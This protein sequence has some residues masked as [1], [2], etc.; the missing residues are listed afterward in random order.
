[1]ASVNKVLIVG[2]GI[3][4]Q[5]F[6]C[7]LAKRGIQAD[8]IELADEF[9]I[10]GAGMI[11]RGTALRALLDIDVVDRIVETGWSDTVNGLILQD[12]TGEPFGGGP[13]PQIAG[14]EYPGSVCLRR[15]SVHEILHTRVT[16]MGL[17]VRMGMTVDQLTNS[18]DGVDVVFS[19]GSEDRYDLVFGCDGIHSKTR[20]MVFP[21]FDPEFAGFCNYRLILPR[22]ESIQTMVWMFGFGKTVGVLPVN[23]TH[24]Y[25][26]CVAK[27]ATPERS[28]PEKALEE[29][30]ARYS[31][32]GRYMQDVM[33]MDI[34][35]SD[36]LHTVM[37]QIKLPAPWYDGRIVIMGDAAHASCPF[38]ASGAAMGIEDAVAY[39]QELEKGETTDAVNASWMERRFERALFVQQG[40]FETGQHLTLD[41][42][43]N[44]PKFFPPPVR[45]GMAKQG[46]A[47]GKRLSEP[48]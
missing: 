2:A 20:Q 1:M 7:S 40:S 32:F 11:L 46:M 39:A 9:K 16:E 13:E 36:I 44:E 18:G 22:P 33:A 3:V 24:I 37:E 5:T 21:G 4:G 25:V 43:S 29:F 26:A 28:P 8:I 12:T 10:L 48:F 14:P 30:R 38:W 47:I 15:H 42:E 17:S 23:D 35:P 19:D 45:E 41:E 27:A 34:Q 31:H 6:A